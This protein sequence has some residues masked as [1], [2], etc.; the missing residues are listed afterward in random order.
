MNKH[1]LAD[2]CPVWVGAMTNRGVVVVL[3]GW[4]GIRVATIS[5]D[6]DYRGTEHDDPEE[7]T[8]DLSHRPTLLAL[9][10]MIVMVDP[11]QSLEI[12]YSCG[13]LFGCL[14][15]GQLES[16]ELDDHE[17]IKALWRKVDPLKEVSDE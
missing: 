16:V 9:A 1:R 10:D 7:L 12:G 5:D 14:T 6:G 3:D 15:T 2:D 13:E 11:S 4:Y 17:G 8:L